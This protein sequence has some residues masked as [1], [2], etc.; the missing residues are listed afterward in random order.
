MELLSLFI[1]VDRRVH[2]TRVRGGGG[3]VKGLRLC[4]LG[5]CVCV[6]ALISVAIYG[7][8]RKKKH[9]NRFMC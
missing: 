8:K 5:V 6:C 4:V 1:Q 3:E 2:D 9:Q 7:E